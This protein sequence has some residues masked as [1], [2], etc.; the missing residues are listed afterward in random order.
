VDQGVA[1]PQRL[2]LYGFSYGAVLVNRLV[3]TDGRFRAAVSHE[4]VA[5][6]ALR[7][8]AYGPDDIP[9]GNAPIERVAAITTPI[10]L[11]SGS[12]APNREQA[13]AFADALVAAGK[14]VA[15]H[16]FEGEGHELK[17]AA[18]TSGLYDV[19][20]AWYRQHDRCRPASGSSR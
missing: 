7:R 20:A 13:E 4:G 14:T 17:G 11:V 2:F 18:K 3:T 10:L 19:S 16:V 6:L 15:L 1:D 9:T 12:S 5:D 8:Q